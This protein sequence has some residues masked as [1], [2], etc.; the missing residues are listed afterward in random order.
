M[1]IVFWTSRFRQ[2][3][4]RFGPNSPMISCQTHLWLVC[5][6]HLWLVCQTH[7]WLVCQTHL[8]LWNCNSRR[9][10]PV[11]LSKYIAKYEQIWKW[12]VEFLSKFQ[13]RG[14]KIDRVNLIRFA[15]SMIFFNIFRAITPWVTTSWAIVFFALS[16]RLLPLVYIFDCMSLEWY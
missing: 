9:V 5:Q 2:E 12:M 1:F 15:K 7:L 6:T 13:G 16:L 14:I 8:W 11:T 10:E 4:I 3:T